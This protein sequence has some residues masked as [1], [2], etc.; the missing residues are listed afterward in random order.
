MAALITAAT[1][2]ATGT[3]IVRQ[4]DIPVNIFSRG[5]GVGESITFSQS[6]DGGTTYVDSYQGGSAV[7]LTSTDNVKSVNAPGFFKV[8]KGVTASASGV[9][10]SKG[11][12]PE[13]L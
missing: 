8:T 5:L 6:Y 9:Y 12:R 4:D 10:I 3:F 11:D 13:S 2:A 7:T 1:G